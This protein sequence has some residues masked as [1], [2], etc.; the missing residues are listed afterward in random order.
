MRWIVEYWYLILAGLAAAI[1]FFGY[2]SKSD[3]GEM[4]GTNSEDQGSEKTHKGGHS[5]CS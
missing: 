5:C 4:S 1:F 3:E 2:K